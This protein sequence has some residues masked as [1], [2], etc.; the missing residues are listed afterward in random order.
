[1]VHPLRQAQ[2]AFPAIMHSFLVGNSVGEPKILYRA[3]FILGICDLRR[4]NHADDDCEWGDEVSGA[5]WLRFDG[6]VRG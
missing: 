1:M 4:D 6:Y 2:G 5:P 3:E